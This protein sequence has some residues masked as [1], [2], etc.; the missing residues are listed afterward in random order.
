M[1]QSQQAALVDCRHPWCNWLAQWSYEPLVW[2]RTPGGVSCLKVFFIFY[3]LFYFILLLIFFLFGFHCGTPAMSTAAVHEENKK[4]EQSLLAKRRELKDTTLT[5]ASSNVEHLRTIHYAPR[6][7]LRGHSGKVY[8]LHWSSDNQHLVSASQDGKLIIWD[9]YS[10]NKVYAI[11]LRSSWVMTCAYSPSSQFVACGGLDNVCTVYSLKRDNV[12]KVRELQGH[13]GYISC[14]RFINDEEM[15]TS[16]GDHTCVLW[17]IEQSKS[18]VRF[19]GHDGD[20]M[21]LSLGPTKQTFV[22]GA[23]DSQAKL[24]DIRTGHCVQTF[25]GHEQDINA[26]AFFP[27]GQAFATGSDDATCRLF[28]LRADQELACFK[29]TQQDEQ[30]VTSV[31]FSMSGRLLYAGYGD[32]TCNVWDTLKVERVGALQD[33]AGRVSCLGVSP[34]GMALCTGSWDAFLKIWN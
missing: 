9:T 14:C 17:D 6:R 3:F 24:W 33:H 32:C 7:T 12:T 29:N 15:V 8:A 16:S 34:D 19:E 31:C 11:P 23:C 10:N 20:V 30:S 22:S 27:D 4:L 26:V 2:V 28:D 25:K 18:K 21:A 13:R 1:M 5:D